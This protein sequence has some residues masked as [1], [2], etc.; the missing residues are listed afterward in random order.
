VLCAIFSVPAWLMV[1]LF[2]CWGIH[3]VH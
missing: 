3:R 2:R 1:F